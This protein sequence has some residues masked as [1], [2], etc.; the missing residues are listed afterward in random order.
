MIKFLLWFAFVIGLYK[1]EAKWWMWVIFV[2]GTIIAL[3]N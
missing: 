3:D 2:I 1:I